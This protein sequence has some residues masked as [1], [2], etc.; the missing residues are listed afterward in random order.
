MNVD[1]IHGL[2][3]VSPV[4]DGQSEGGGAVD[5]LED[6]DDAVRTLEQVGHFVRREI[7]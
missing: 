5:L 7:G 4:L 6:R 3:G 1:V 2:P